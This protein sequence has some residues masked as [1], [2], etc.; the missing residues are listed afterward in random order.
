MSPLVRT[1]Q[2]LLMLSGFAVLGYAVLWDMD[3]STGW[4]CQVSVVGDQTRQPTQ[5]CS[6]ED[7]VQTPVLLGMVG[8]ALEI[9]SVSVAVGARGRDSAGSSSPAGPAFFGAAPFGA[10]QPPQAPFGSGQPPQ[11]FPPP[12]PFGSA[13]PSHAPG[14]PHNPWPPQTPPQGQPGQR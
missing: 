2:I 12:Q 9:A 14:A 7:G 11:A 3:D 1:L 5:R 10:G 6:T 4:E 8:V 13:Q